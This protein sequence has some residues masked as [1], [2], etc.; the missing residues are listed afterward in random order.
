MGSGSSKTVFKHGDE[1]KEGNRGS[2]EQSLDQNPP[3]RSVPAN[4]DGAA[5]GTHAVIN[6]D[7]SAP[8]QNPTIVSFNLLYE[9]RRKI[10][11]PSSLG[12]HQ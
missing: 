1:N 3:H 12:C 5:F 7:S 10:S 6:G 8:R 9:C 4:P 2:S 11:S